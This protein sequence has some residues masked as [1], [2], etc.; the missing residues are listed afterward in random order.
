E[1]SLFRIRGSAA[2]QM[3]AGAIGGAMVRALFQNSRGT[4]WIGTHNGIASY[5][6]ERF[7]AYDSSPPLGEIRA[8]AEDR[9]GAI[10]AG[11]PGGLF[12]QTGGAFQKWVPSGMT[13]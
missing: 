1:R 9:K 11:G 12:H 3:P 6:G 10:W 2:T 13:E 8:I 4:I 7:H 5:D